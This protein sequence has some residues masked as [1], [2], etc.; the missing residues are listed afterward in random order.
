[1]YSGLAALKYQL[2]QKFAVSARVEIF[3][4][5]QGFMSGVV[6]NKDNFYTGYKLRGYTLGAEFK[7]TPNSYIRMEGRQL[8]MERNQEIF[9]WN[10]SNRSSR[11]EFLLNLGISFSN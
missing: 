4:D 3:Q 8:Q 11:L 9:R 10:G 6:L 1:M 5:P 2:N 7:P